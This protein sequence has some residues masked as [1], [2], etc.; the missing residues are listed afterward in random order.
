M[1]KGLFLAVLGALLVLASPASAAHVTPTTIAGNPS[2]EGG[3]KIE[4][5]ADGTYAVPGGSITI[6]V[7]DKSFDFTTSGV[8]VFQVIV[9]GGPNAN[10][11]DYAS[12]GGVTSDT[13]LSAPLHG[14]KPAGLSHLCFFTDDEKPPPPPK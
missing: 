4:P 11:Y 3:T 2:C 9:K 13:G 12:L 8:T 7:T 6:D 1:R 14:G 10:L 5:V